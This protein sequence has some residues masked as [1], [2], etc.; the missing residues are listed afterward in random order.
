MCC[1]KH[2]DIQVMAIIKAFKGLRPEDDIADKV[3][4]RPYDTMNTAE[5]RAE[6][7]G[8]P[9]SFLRV[10]KPEI[11]LPEGTDPYADVVY[12]MGAANLQEFV[13]NGWL[14]PDATDCLYIYRQIMG[15]HAQVGLV[16]CSSIHDYFDDVIKKHEYTRPV[17]EQDRIK[18]M[19]TLRAHQGPVFL[20]YPDVFDIDEVIN[21][22]IASDDPEI[23]FAAGDNVRHTIWVI[24]DRTIIRELERLFRTKVPATYIAD[25]HHRAASSA[26]VGQALMKENPN[27]TG[28]EEYNFFLSVLFPADQ[29]SII[30][31]NRVVKDLNGLT[32]EEF[33]A[34]VSEKFNIRPCE[35][36]AKPEFNGEFGLYMDGIWYMLEAPEEMLDEPDPV[37][38]LDIS[39]LSNNIIDPILGIKDQRTDDRIDFVGGIRGLEELERRVDS[40]EMACAFSIF[41]VSIH[42]LIAVSESGRVMPPKTTWFEPKLRSG[43]VVH[44]F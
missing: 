18:H 3:A 32:S 11:D 5:A 43:L 20:T 34:A 8:N 26:K 13:Q 35:E 40:G 6:A 4:S 19:R 27:H 23:D 25:G 10:I 24:N 41:P 29:L 30:D 21:G 31:Y 2:S 15:V 17:K 42:Q 12:K 16:A 28:E 38:S 44:K 39:I 14:K 33:L 22:V 7:E 9:M 1:S 37:E 36:A